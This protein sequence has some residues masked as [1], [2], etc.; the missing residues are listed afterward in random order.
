VGWYIGYIEK[1][2]NTFY[3]ATCI[4][5]TNFNDTEFT[6]KRIEITNKIFNEL[7]VIN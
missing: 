6:K 4:Q 1:E 7:R 5:S 3:F 2:N